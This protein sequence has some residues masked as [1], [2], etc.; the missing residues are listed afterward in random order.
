[1]KIDSFKKKDYAFTADLY[2]FTKTTD[3][4][5][6]EVDNYSL[7]RT[8]SLIVVTGI[9]GKLTCYLQDAESDVQIK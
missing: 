9:F 5:G 6:G 1:M 7:N 3:A 4:E 8:I 2:T